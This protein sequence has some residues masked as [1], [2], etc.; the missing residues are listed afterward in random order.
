MESFVYLGSEVTKDGGDPTQDV[1]QRIQ[2]SNGAFVQLYPVAADMS[3]LKYIFAFTSE[4][5][6]AKMAAVSVVRSLSESVNNSRRSL[7]LKKRRCRGS[8]STLLQR[9]CLKI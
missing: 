5:V 3:H 2:K 8:L 4:P 1:A 7:D 6:P 9:N